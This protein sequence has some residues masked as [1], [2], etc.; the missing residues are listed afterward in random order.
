M[1]KISLLNRVS[2][3]I[4][5]TPAEKAKRLAA[6]RSAITAVRVASKIPTTQQ[7]VDTFPGTNDLGIM[8]GKLRSIGMM[9][10]PSQQL[11]QSPVGKSKV[12]RPN[13]SNSITNLGQADALFNKPSNW[14]PI[15]TMEIMKK[16]RAKGLR[17]P[18]EITANWSYL[19]EGTPYKE[20]MKH[21]DFNKQFPNYSEKIKG[22]IEE[23]YR[24][25]AAPAINLLATR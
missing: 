23:G 24:K 16:A 13:D 6:Q 7:Q 17:T 12:I 4:E 1:S 2:S 21:P 19:I 8:N 18:A 5:E 11:D 9:G 10:V 20:A 3:P 14:V 22:L 15:Q 25:E